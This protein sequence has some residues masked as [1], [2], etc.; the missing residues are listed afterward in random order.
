MDNFKLLLLLK[1]YNNNETHVMNVLINKNVDSKSGYSCNLILIN[2]RSM[3]QNLNLIIS[4]THHEA[5][6]R[7]PD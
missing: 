7:G 6:S 4:I 3:S 1:L 2:I 5:G